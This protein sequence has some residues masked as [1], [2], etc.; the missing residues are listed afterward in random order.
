MTSAVCSPWQK[1]HKRLWAIRPL[2]TLWPMPDTV[3]GSKR[4]PVNPKALF[5][6]F[7]S[8][9]LLTT[10]EMELFSTV[11]NFTTTTKQILSGVRRGRHSNEIRRTERGKQLDIRHH[12]EA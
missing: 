2:L 11:P 10:R 1:L 7:P 3:M 6:M 5:R 12:Q 8:F 9:V 4:K